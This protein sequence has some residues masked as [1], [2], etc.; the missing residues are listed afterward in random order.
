[1]PIFEGGMSSK[2]FLREKHITVTAT[3][4]LKGKQRYSL[5]NSLSASCLVSRPR[6]LFPLLLALAGL[7]SYPLL[8]NLWQSGGATLAALLWMVFQRSTYTIYLNYPTSSLKILKSSDKRRALRT[9]FAINDA[10][11]YLNCK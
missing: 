10:I 11:W 7:I 5:E 4:L 9:F 8:G 2:V 3:E 1:M 6:R